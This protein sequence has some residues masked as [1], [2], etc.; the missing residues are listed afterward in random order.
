MKKIGRKIPKVFTLIR[1]KNLYMVQL[2]VKMLNIF[3]A[4]PFVTKSP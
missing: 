1:N 3:T 2:S 4:W